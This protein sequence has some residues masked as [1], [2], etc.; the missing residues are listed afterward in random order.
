MIRETLVAAMMFSQIAPGAGGTSSSLPVS[1]SVM[2]TIMCRIEQDGRGELELLLLWR[3]RP[4]WM[5]S[6][7]GNT[8]GASASGGGG[9]LGSGRGAPL[10]RTAWFSQGGV[11]FQIR[12]EPQ[13]GRLWIQDREVALNGGNAVL[14]DDV[15]SAN[16]PQV[17]RTLRV[18]PAFVPS[19]A[20]T[21]PQEFIR[22]SPEL[23][24]FLRCDVPLTG[25]QPYEQQVFEMMCAA[26]RQP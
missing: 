5:R 1:P 18:D 21:L 12:F 11:S 7:D 14:V 22:R 8:G 3:G 9:S 15:D 17:V 20:P 16:G 6:G 26:V 4:G 2:A 23:V 25:L 13:A 24:E 19:R 10:T